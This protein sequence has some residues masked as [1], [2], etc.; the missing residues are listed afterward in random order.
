MKVADYAQPFH[1]GRGRI[2]VLFLH[3]FNSSPHALREW[4]QL[5]ADAGYRVALPRLPGH[6]TDWRELNATRWRDWYSCAERELLAL[7]AGADQ[8]FIAGHSMGGSLGLRLAAHLPDAVAGLSLVNPGMLAYP[9]QRLAPLASRVVDTVPSRRHDIAQPGVPRHGYDHTP[10]RAAVSMFRMYADIR[11][12]LDLVVCPTLMFRSAADH[13]VPTL[14][15]DYIRTHVSSEEV[16][17]RELPRSYHV[18]T[19]DYDKEQVFSETLGFI[20][21]HSR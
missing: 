12:S 15:I 4:A 11:A 19:L 7:D 2:A 17:V 5:T 8:V 10:L 3:G 16:V 6:G 21:A 18:A 13:V 14:S 20:A 1:A 9:L